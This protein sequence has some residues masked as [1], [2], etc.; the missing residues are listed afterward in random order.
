MK[1]IVWDVESNGLLDTVDKV[2]CICWKEV[3]KE[4]L[5]YLD[6]DNLHIDNLLDVFSGCKK[7]IGHNIINYDIPLLKKMYN[8]DLVKLLGPE[9]IWDTYI[10]SRLH[11][12]DRPLPKGCPESVFNPVTKRKDKVGPHSLEA[13]GYFV[14]NKKIEIVDWREY[15]PIILERCMVDVQINDKVY[16][17]LKQ[18]MNFE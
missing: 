5:Y 13:W 1:E 16:L 7:I 14:G 11:W 12:P 18:E 2:H 15:K 17:H 9:V 3:G 8:V 6:Y 4:D 10:M